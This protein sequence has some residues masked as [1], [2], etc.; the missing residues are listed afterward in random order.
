M[1]TCTTSLITRLDLCAAFSPGISLAEERD[2]GHARRVTY[3]AW[4]L[5]VRA[6]MSE[7]QQAQ[8]F[9]AALLHDLGIIPVARQLASLPINHDAD[10]LRRHADPGEGPTAERR[11]RTPATALLAAHPIQGAQMA[12]QAGLPHS[13]ARL[14]ALHHERWDGG[15]NPNQRAGRDLPLAAL[16]LAAADGLEGRLT[17]V[18][19]PRPGYAAADFARE[20]TAAIGPEASALL[21]EAAAD[22]SFWEPVF[23]G[24][25]GAAAERPATAEL[26]AP[27][28]SWSEATPWGRFVD[29]KSAYGGSHSSRVAQLAADMAVGIGLSA[30]HVDRIGW[31]GL[32]HDVGRL[33]IPCRI[34]DRPGSLSAEEMEMVRRHPRVSREM[35]SALPDAVDIARWA[36]THHERLDGS[37]YPYGLSGSELPV[38]T[39]LLAIADVYD[40]LISDRPFRPR[41]SEAEAGAELAR[42]SQQFDPVLLRALQQVRPVPE[43][44]AAEAI[45]G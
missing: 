3:L 42:N 24:W 44:R 17:A 6:G 41:F 28:G 45:R 23:A 19:P 27:I 32:L 4:Q 11:P 2:P 7:M 12:L 10:L 15:G 35:V 31:A 40:A 14:I 13:V 37:G 29:S 34:S 25:T 39:R 21:A 36:A 22:P 18:R 26:T 33:A 38:E 1:S 9:C 16:L 8:L 20:M 43:E 30:D 5:A